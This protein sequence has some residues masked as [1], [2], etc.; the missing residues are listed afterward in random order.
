MSPPWDRFLAKCSYQW[1]PKG[2]S[3]FQAYSIS[4]RFFKIIT[5]LE[6]ISIRYL[7]MELLA[8]WLP[9]M[10]QWKVRV[11]CSLEPG[12]SNIGKVPTFSP[13]FIISWSLGSS[14]TCCSRVVV[15]ELWGDLRNR[16][17]SWVNLSRSRDDSQRQTT[18]IGWNCRSNATNLGVSKDQVVVQTLDVPERILRQTKLKWLLEIEISPKE[19]QIYHWQTTWDGGDPPSDW[20]VSG[21]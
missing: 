6:V 18:L 8:G 10:P 9:Q 17:W 5:P 19:E 11:L 21:F 1:I 12:L 3:R 14:M 16:W 7:E 2:T 13:V 4:L 20:C 15:S